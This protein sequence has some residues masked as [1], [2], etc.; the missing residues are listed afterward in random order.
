MFRP[1]RMLRLSVVILERDERRVLRQ[2]GKGGIMQLTRTPAG[3]DTAPLAPP[4]RSAGLARCDQILARLERLRQALDLP[5]PSEVPPD[6][7][8]SFLDL[9]DEKLGSLEEQA[10]DLLK[11]RQTLIQRADELSENRKTMSI[12][13]GLQIPLNDPE[14]F[15]FLHFVTGR[16]PAGNLETIDVGEN[17]AV[18]PLPEQNGWQPVIVMTTRQRWQTLQSALQQA[19]FKSENFPVAEGTD[20]DSFLLKRQEERQR[21][22]V[23]LET[24]N[25]KL[26]ELARAFAQPLAEIESVV[27]VERRLLEAEQHFPHT[28][29]AVLLGGWV[30]AA[31]ARTLE[32]Q[33][34]QAT[35]GRCVIQATTPNKAENIPVFLRHR[36]LFR[37]FEALVTAYG[38]P[39]YWEIEPTVLVAVSYLL[40]F[41]MMFGDVGDGVILA[42]LGLLFRLVG[43]RQQIRDAGLLLLFGGI[44]S[45]AFGVLYG[46]YFGIPCLKKLALWHDPLSGDT[47]RLMLVSIGIGFVMISLGL[48]LNVLNRFRRGDAVGG[49]LDKFGLAGLLFYWGLLVVGINYAALRSRGLAMAAFIAFFVFPP[50]VWM[51]KDPVKLF[52][53]RPSGQPVQENDSLLAR[54]LESLAEVFEGI[55]SYLSNTISFVRLAAYSMSHAALLAATFTVADDLRH[56]PHGGGFLS[57]FT[58]MLGNIIALVLEGIVASVQALRLEYYEFF[59]KFFSG[60]GQP[61]RPFRLTDE[62]FVM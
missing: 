8:E 49:C 15:S 33:V 21:I 35:D 13:Q 14:Q 57:I 16:L 23:E 19:G 3:R 51:L 6:L 22:A 43:R 20:L 38:W 59:G 45:V 52:L 37:P 25:L 9:A 42:L 12:Y 58:I 44:S 48:L 55:V 4:D 61:F 32:Q 50:A 7:P 34:R 30:P 31:D 40:M 26:R 2:L 28:E 27:S 60:A 10:G 11:R 18:L 36:W 5:R 17:V 29:A 54:V 24:L 53:A 41:G 1:L 39:G 46:S 47:L 62:N 56:L